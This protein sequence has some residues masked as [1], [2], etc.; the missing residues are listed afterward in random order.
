MIENTTYTSFYG[1][2]VYNAENLSKTLS[3]MYTI[4]TLSLKYPY[5]RRLVNSERFNAVCN[6]CIF[7]YF[8]SSYASLNVVKSFDGLLT[9]DLVGMSNLCRHRN[10]FE[11]E[12]ESSVH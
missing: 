11:N 2:A 5:Q 9:V 1:S 3:K 4:T 10:Y 7:F 6:L 12:R 8:K